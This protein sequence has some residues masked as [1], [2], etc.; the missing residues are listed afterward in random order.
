MHPRH[1]LLAFLLFNLLWAITLF[2]VVQGSISSPPAAAPDPVVAAKPLALRAA[3]ESSTTRTATRPPAPPPR[4]CTWRDLE[5]QEYMSY[6]ARLRAAGCPEPTVR[7]IVVSDVNERTGS[8]RLE[9]ALSD[10][11]SWWRAEAD[12]NLAPAFPDVIY[13]LEQERHALLEK[14][15]GSP[16]AESDP[17]PSLGAGGVLLTGLALGSISAEKYNRLQEILAAAA[18]REQDYLR[19]RADDGQLPNPVELARQRE[20]TR[21]E[22]TQILSPLELDEFLLRYSQNARQL[23]EQLRDFQPSSN[24]FRK[25]FLA[26]DRID[27]RLQLEYGAASALSAKQRQEYE[28]RRDRAVEQVLSPERYVDYRQALS[29]ALAARYP[30]A[31]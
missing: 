19:A 2:S 15:L 3:T 1:R 12:I 5:S 14:L 11:P 24:E 25:I 27:H 23:R 9:I 20:Q 8:R 17:T 30:E 10:D 18:A 16:W 28:R 31:R 7:Q 22:L 13:A 29:R 26:T 6:L 21:T 4:V